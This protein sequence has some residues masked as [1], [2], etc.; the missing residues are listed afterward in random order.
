ME[1]VVVTLAYTLTG[2]DTEI[3]SQLRTVSDT[4][5]TAPGLT[6]LRSYRGRQ[7]GG[8]YALFLCTWDSENSWR[9]A[10]E[11]YSPHKLLQEA[12]KRQELLVI[13]P[14]QWVMHYVWGYT[15][16]LAAPT[17]AAIHL[18]SAPP[19]QEVLLQNGWRRT[20]QHHVQEPALAYAFLAHSTTPTTDEAHEGPVT[21][22]FCFFSWS[23]QMERD[24]FYSEKQIRTMHAFS[25]QGSSVQILALEPL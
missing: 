19:E 10:Q 11:Q 16:P 18:M 22:L 12:H 24:L 15:R 17:L 5:Q 13:D 23:S 25:E 2:R 21:V 3:V 4:L 20:L 7:K 8:A 14:L 1:V 9:K 6:H